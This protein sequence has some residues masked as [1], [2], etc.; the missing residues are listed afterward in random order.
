[1]SPSVLAA[2]RP[3]IAI[4]F[5]GFA[6]LAAAV[7]T[8]SHAQ[9]P[10]PAAATVP[11]SIPAPVPVPVPAPVNDSRGH[12]LPVPAGDASTWGRTTESTAGWNDPR[13][14]CGRELAGTVWY[15]VD[16][17]PSTDLVLRLVAHGWLDATLAA[18]R[19]VDGKLRSIVCDTAGENG[20]STIGFRAHEGDLILVGQ[21]SGSEAGRFRLL[22]L[23]PQPAERAP[24]QPL[25]SGVRSTV[26]KY[27]DSEDIWNVQLR[28][29]QTYRLRFQGDG[30]EATMFSPVTGEEVSR[31]Y[32]SGYHLFTPGPSGGGRYLIHVTAGYRDGLSRY[33]YRVEPA[34]LD[35]TGPGRLLHAGTWFS[36]ELD[37]RGVDVVDMYR[38]E[39]SARSDILLALGRP[40]S[41]GIE[42]R[43]MGDDGT[44]IALGQAIRRPLPAGSYAVS[45]FDS[46]GRAAVGYRL[47]LRVHE[48]SRLVTSSRTVMQ[49]TSVLLASSVGR[50]TGRHVT[51]ELDRL[52]PI[53]GWVFARVYEL[54]VLA[55][56]T[57]GLTWLPSQVGRYRA[58]ITRPTRSGY[59]YVHV[60][61]PH[62]ADP[63]Q[64]QR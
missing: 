60:I 59:V 1:M 38:F 43:L 34:R 62:P 22:T 21:V 51:L 13:Y 3:R 8:S 9:S 7:S 41:K 23:V 44:S 33:S 42:L 35:D 49:G 16:T 37:P 10:A 46:P 27:L 55:G 2:L 4:L 30:D 15:R 31:F 57:A 45:V 54:P 17:P 40:R 48:V 29:G 12:A 26:E 24:G 47:A 32:S 25:H 14:A 64:P 39:L 6:V 18:Y 53:Q 11:S 52:D 50:P 61:D 56:R 20:V 19:F 5:I 58:R 63:T 36:G 28:A